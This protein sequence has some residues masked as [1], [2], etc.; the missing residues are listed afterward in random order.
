MADDRTPTQTPHVALVT[1]ANH[2]IGAGTALALA[3]DGCAV[4]CAYW[5][6][7]DAADPGVPEAYRTSRLAD[8]DWVVERIRERGGRAVA[9]EADL[10]DPGAAAPLFDAAERELGPVDILVNNAT[11]WVADTFK[12]VST[13]RH[14]RSLQPVT[15]ATWSQQFAV[16]TMA[17]ALLIAEFARRHAERGATWGRIIGLTSGGEGGFP[18]EVSYGA[19]KAAQVNYTLSAGVEL[20]GLGITANVVHPPVTDTGWVTDSVREF[21]ANSGDHVHVASPDEVGRVIAYLASEQARLFT[22]NVI[23]LR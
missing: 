23:R 11:G 22:G 12:P 4:L 7:R 13:D 2:G 20:A 8:A 15:A 18:E 3:D 10:R 6:V 1:G 9:V 16:D 5:R 14:G 21:V 19:A 17:P